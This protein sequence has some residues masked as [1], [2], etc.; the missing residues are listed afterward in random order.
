MDGGWVWQ[1]CPLTITTDIEMEDV[2]CIF[3]QLIADT[4][5]NN[6]DDAVQS[7]IRKS[8]EHFQ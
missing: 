4:S 3:S 8:L 1:S 5:F 7:T 6:L 2:L